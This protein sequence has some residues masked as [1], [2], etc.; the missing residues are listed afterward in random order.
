MSWVD[1]LIIGII[2]LSIG[3]SFTRGFTREALSLLTWVVAIWVSVTYYHTVGDM[4]SGVI[5][6]P[7]ARLV[8]AFVVLF[9]ITIIIG[10]TLSFILSSVINKV[11]LNGVNRVVGMG[12]GFLRGVLVIG[13]LVLLS[14]H[15]AMPEDPWY[16]NSQFIP[17]FKPVADMISELMPEKLHK[18]SAVMNGAEVLIK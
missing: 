7:S 8:F 16:K 18:I 4:L 13:I 11:G 14:G 6:T 17:Y 5:E 10:S 3:I 9:L 2:L 1:Y 12:F 15:T